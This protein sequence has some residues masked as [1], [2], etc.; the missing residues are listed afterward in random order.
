MDIYWN[1]V[2][3]DPDIEEY[4]RYIDQHSKSKPEF[5]DVFKEYNVKNVCDSACGFGAYSAM[6]SANGY[7]VVGFDVAKSS[8]ELTKKLLNKFEI[9][10]CEYIVSSITNISL[11]DEKFDAVI[12]HAVIDHLAYIDAI[13]AIE[14]LLRIVKNKGL[15]YIS[16][17]GIE[18]DDMKLEHI[19]LDDGS[20]LY[21]DRS[22]DGLLFKYY[23]DTDI[24][25]LLYGRTIIYRKTNM[26]GDREIIIQK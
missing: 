4:Q 16:F 19:I 7:Q 5:L 9:N 17:D 3:K 21:S 20:F 1:E 14:E 24:N 18:D 10:T 25:T 22:R 26:H 13:R 8:I 15:V 6:L 23:S 11:K 2:W 12:A